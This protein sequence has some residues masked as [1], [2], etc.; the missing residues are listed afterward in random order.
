MPSKAMDRMAQVA[1]RVNHEQLK[2]VIKKY[3]KAKRA[4]FIWGSIGIGKSHVIRDAGRDLATELKLEFT[5][6]YNHIND[7]KYF[8]IIDIRLSQCDPS[9]LRGI[10]VYDKE[11]Q[12]TLWLPPSTFPR[13][14]HGIILFDELNLSPPLVQ[15]SAYQFILDRRLGE[16]VVPEGYSVI[17]AGNRLEDRSNVFEMSAALANRQ[18]HVQL[19][20][21]SVDDWTTWASK[22]DIDLRVVGYL[23]FKQGSLFAFDPALKEK[24]FPTPRVWQFVSDLIK[25]IPSDNLPMLKLFVGSLVGEG[26]AV[27]FT[28][29]LKVREELAPI[30]EYFAKPDTIEIPTKVDLQWALVTSVVEYYKAHNEEKTLLSMIKLLKRFSE[31]YAVFTLKLAYAIDPSLQAKL[32]K[33]PEATN[34]ATKLWKYIM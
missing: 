11:R 4:L 26:E 15:A 18:G 1:I 21:P 17:G 27:T 19:E 23:N 29:F 12:A 32:Q 8:L 30:K 3:F 6:D 28:G 5:E 24:S 13:K 16:Y 22:H 31:E 7:E 9:D 34:L 20:P 2:Q 25:D 33:I 14:G 10:P